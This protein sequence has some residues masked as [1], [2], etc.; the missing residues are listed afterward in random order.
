MHNSEI[1][2]ISEVVSKTNN[3]SLLRKMK[4]DTSRI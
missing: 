4:I 3:S 1:Q 2:L